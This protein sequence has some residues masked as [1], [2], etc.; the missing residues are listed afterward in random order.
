MGSRCSSRSSNAMGERTFARAAASSIASGRPSSRRQISPTVVASPFSP[1]VRLDRL[2]PF[3]EERDRVLVGELRDWI[4]PLARDPQRPLLEEIAF[5][6]RALSTSWW[7]CGAA[8]RTC[9]RLSS[10]SSSSR[11][12]T[13][14]SRA[15]S[16]DRP[17]GSSPRASERW[18]GSP[19]M[20]RPHRPGR[21]RRRRRRSRRADP[22]QPAARAS[23]CPRRRGPSR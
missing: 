7:I 5:R 12:C 6:A 13:K 4:L 20:A 1:E 21:R 15:S 14:R 11:S 19:A 18:P 10:T 16:A 9:S 2:R 22:P 8:S 3:A 17:P 23:S